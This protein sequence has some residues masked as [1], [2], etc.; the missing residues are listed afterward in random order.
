MTL[1]EST[2]NPGDK[3][4][5]VNGLTFVTSSNAEPFL[6]DVVVDYRTGLF[7]KGFTIRS[8]GASRC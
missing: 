7:G 6:Q 2:A 3:T 4:Y 5:T 8:S 1:E